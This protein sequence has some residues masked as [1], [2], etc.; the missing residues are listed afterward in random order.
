MRS[1][2]LLPGPGRVGLACRVDS[3]L[4]LSEVHEGGGQTSKVGDVVEKQLGS[5]VHLFFIAPL[6]NLGREGRRKGGREEKRMGGKRGNLHTP[7]MWFSNYV[8]MNSQ[9]TT[10]CLQPYSMP[11]TYQSKPLPADTNDS[12]TPVLAHSLVVSWFSQPSQ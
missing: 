1:L 4:E 12:T 11:V 8:Y 10:S 3:I 6:S 9:R 5:F 7:M 2:Y